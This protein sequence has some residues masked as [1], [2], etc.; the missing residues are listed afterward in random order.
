MHSPAG[1]SLRC[2]L[3]AVLGTALLC[4]AALA[5]PPVREP[6]R[7]AELVPGGVRSSVTEAWGTLDFKLTN[8]TD[9]DREARVLV[10]FA[11]QP[12][13]QYGRDV[14]VPA[15]STRST[16]LAVGPASAQS[17]AGAR[18]IESLLYD[19]TGGQDRLI[20]PPT[21]ERVRSR[22]VP[23]RKREPCTSILLDDTP[24]GAAF[25]ELPQP[26][27]PAEE[28][29][30][31]A[32]TYRLALGM[33]EQ[34]QRLYGPLPATPEGFDGT[35]YFV[36]ASARLAQ[37]PVGVR[38]LRQWLERGGKVWV[39]LDRID[40]DVVAP[41]LGD[42]LD[43]QVVDRI[44]LTSFKVEAPH[45]GRAGQGPLQHYDRPVE[46]ARV[47]LPPQERVSHF[48]NGWPAWFLRPVG[49]GR[50]LFTALGPR[51]WIRPRKATDGPSPYPEFPS[52]SVPLDALRDLAL[53]EQ[54]LEPVGAPP[55]EAFRPLLTQEIGYSVVSRGTVAG[56]FAGSLAVGLALALVLRRARRRE[57]VG[58]LGPAAALGAALVLLALGEWARRA[59]PP[60]VAVGE[61]VTPG[62]GTDEAAV[63]GLLEVYRPES[64]PAD[65]G[66]RRGG[67]FDLDMTGGEGRGRRLV[68]TDLDA[69]H[70][71]NVALP[72]GVRSGPFRCT[73]PTGGPLAAFARPGPNGLEGRVQ[74]GPFQ[75]LADAVLTSAGDR[76]L[77]VRL[78]PD[79]GFGTGPEEPLP[80]G[81]FLPGAVLS[82]VQQRRQEIYR[83]LLKRTAA[84]RGEG[85]TMLLAW[86]RPIDLGFTLPPGARQAGSALLLIPVRLE[87]PE[88]GRRVTLP[89]PLLPFRRLL[90]EQVVR[91][92]LEGTEAADVRLRFQVPPEVL[93]FQVERAR[94]TVRINA[95]GRRVTLA[96]V[97]EGNPVELGRADSPLEPLRVELAEERLLR[98]DAEG[99]LQVHFS[100]SKPLQG[101][102]PGR[103]AQPDQPWKVEYVELEVTGEA[104][105]ER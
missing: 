48:V 23:Y 16:W 86:A 39:P 8:F 36:L 41:F 64:G 22:V 47:L 99:G 54:R 67:L 100:V 19:R 40:P 80:A 37:D 2:P 75:D 84:T 26:A 12:D 6:L 85:R 102:E 57:L 45:L 98:T 49:R 63:Q 29:I 9:A 13:V 7:L 33:S 66:V 17:A 59:T 58:W 46:F 101:G 28:A 5:Q 10:F 56:V 51:A 81:Q 71:E 53:E 1:R 14:W 88:P 3:L 94:F 43:F 27:S 50:V 79:G 44:G 65:L 24:D 69:W 96:G 87:R 21:E 68:L 15:H 82:D 30:E 4:P 77:A 103:N 35:D 91:P 60:T 18:S 31:L 20:L 70:W 95:P 25:G 74:A 11:D 92:T 34:V 90:D 61:V 76:N 52:Q 32:R 104:A 83:D 42:G 105:P 55:V 89:G 72:A 62:P 73:V 38:A 78:G 97:A 93:P